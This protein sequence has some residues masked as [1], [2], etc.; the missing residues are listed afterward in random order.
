[1]LV[2]SFASSWTQGTG[3]ELPRVVI[4]GSIA[5]RKPKEKKLKVLAPEQRTVNFKFIPRVEKVY[6]REALQPAKG[7]IEPLIWPHPPKKQK[8]T[9]YHFFFTPK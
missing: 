4:S 2:V 1:M 5:P 6:N 7:F 9:I 8:N 3:I